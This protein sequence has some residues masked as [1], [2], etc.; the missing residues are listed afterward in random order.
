M[1]RVAKAVRSKRAAKVAAPMAP[2]VVPRAKVLLVPK[3]IARKVIV[4]AHPTAAQIVKMAPAAISNVQ[5]VQNVPLIAPMI[6]AA[7]AHAIP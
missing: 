3:V 1:H 2:A 6:A 5:S 7:T 4:A